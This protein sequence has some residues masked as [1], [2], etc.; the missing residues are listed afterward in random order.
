MNP[1]SPVRSGRHPRRHVPR[2]RPDLRG[3]RRRSRAA[4]GLRREGP[5][6]RHDRQCRSPRAFAKLL[7]VHIEDA[8]VA[9]AVRR[10]RSLSQAILLP[11]ARA[12]VVPRRRGRARNGSPRTGHQCWGSRP[13]GPRP[14]AEALL[15][16]GRPRR[17]TSRP[18]SGRT[19]V[20]R[21]KPLSRKAAISPWRSSAPYAASTVVIGDTTDDLL[22][23]RA[24]R[25]C[26][27]SPSP[28]ASTTRAELAPGRSELHRRRPPLR[29]RHPRRRPRP[30]LLPCAPTCGSPSATAPP[31]AVESIT[32]RELQAYLLRALHRTLA[33]RGGAP[34]RVAAR[35]RAGSS[36]GPPS[37][38][39]HA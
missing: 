22:M 32:G 3:H 31:A 25:Q 34:P 37:G 17:P 29:R 15:E 23:A 18:W 16:A 1:L 39:A 36:T 6:R 2:H 5:H 19:E 26:A 20:S 27:P 12:L 9:E 33:R 7:A 28:T 21:P 14:S 24:G 30:A 10:Y 8:L 35:K 11:R 13:P 4:A 38:A